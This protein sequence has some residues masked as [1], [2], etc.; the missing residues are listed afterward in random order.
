MDPTP[1]LAPHVVKRGEA[2]AKDASL[3]QPPPKISMS[4]PYYDVYIGRLSRS[5]LGWSQQKNKIN[6]EKGVGRF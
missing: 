2:T 4:E 1:S 5:R 3:T 6:G